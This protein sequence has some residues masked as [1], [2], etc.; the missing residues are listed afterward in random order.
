MSEVSVYRRYAAAL[1]QLARQAGKGDAWLAQL[2][3]GTAAVHDCRQLRAVLENRFVDL[4]KRRHIV[5]E[6]GRR[7]SLEKPVVSF[8]KLLIDRKR[9]DAFAGIVD[10]FEAS[11]DADAG[12]VQVQVRAARP[13]KPEVLSA[14]KALLSEKLRQEPKLLAK[15]D[16]R[17]IGGL[18]LA[19][20]GNLYDGSVKGRL[21]ALEHT[22]L[23]G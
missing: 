16:S 10:V 13:L 22:L 12:R 11:V 14:L 1:L 20:S 21:D 9:I 3:E 6:L 7:L 5:D 4:N 8:I 2:Q 17:L 23:I 15:T 19:W 18:Q